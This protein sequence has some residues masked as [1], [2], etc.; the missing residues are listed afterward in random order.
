MDLALLDTD[1]Y[2]EILRRRNPTIVRTAQAYRAEHGS[3]SLSAVTVVELVKGFQQAARINDVVDLVYALQ[4]ENVLPLSVE[5]AVLAGQIDGDLSRIGQTIGRAD[6]MIAA[7]AIIHNMVLATGN[8][9][10]FE[11]DQR[12]GFD[13]RIADWRAG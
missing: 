13:L 1:I 8:G 9:R 12:L 7:T 4:V 10:H 5:I 11:R 3:Y 2:S 6:P